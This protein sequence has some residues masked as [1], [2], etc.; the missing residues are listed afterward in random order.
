MS[1][2]WRQNRA[3]E[4]ANLTGPWRALKW[5]LRVFSSITLAVV[6]LLLVALYGVSA[7]VPIGLL[8]LAPTYLFYAAALALTVALLVAAPVW[9]GLRILARASRTVRFLASFALGLAALAVALW[10]WTGVFW[11]ALRFE[12]STGS[13]LRFFGEFVAAN[14]A[15]TLRRLP[16]ME[17]SELE[18]YSWWPLKLVLMLFVMNMV[19]AT[20]RRI[21]FNFRN[22]GVLTVHTGIITIAL[23]SVY[24]SGLKQE[25]DTLLL[26]GELGPSGRPGVGPPQDRFFDNTR[27]AL[28][29]DQGR[30]VEQRV[31]SGVPRYNDYNLGAVAGESA[32]ET[33]GL[34][35]PWA[36]AQR[37]L[38]V[39]VPRSR[40]GLCDPDISL[41]IVGYASYAE[42]VEDYVKVEAG[43]SGAPLRVVYLHSAVPDA[44]TG[45][46]PQGPVFAFFLSPAAP[47]DRVSE[48]D[49]FGV[50]YTLGPS[51]GMSQARW[52]DLSEPLP[53]GAEHGLVVEIPASSFRGA[54][55]AKVGET[56]TI[57]D[58]GYRVEVRELRPT[59][60]FP[61]IT[62]GYRGATS[63]VA[64]VRVTAPDGAAFDRYVYHRFPEINQ[65]VLGATDEGRP[66][67]RDADPAIRVSLVE[68][69]RLQ[70]YI[71]E[72][73][74]GQTRAI[75]RGAQSV[76][77]FE[78]DQIGSEGWIRG[79]A[80]DLVS[81]RVGERWDRAIK[82]E[83]PA[84]VSEE[85]QDRRLAGTHDAAMLGVELR[86]PGAG[87]GFR[88][89][90][91]LPFNKY[92]GIMSGAERKIDLPDGR[93]IS[94]TFG[95]M[96][97][98]FPDF[99]IQLSDFQM[100]AYDHRGAPRDYQSVVRV[101]PMDAATFRQFEH[102]TKLNNPLRAPSHWDESR[103][104]IANAAGRLA[105]GLSPRQFKLS[106][107]GWDAAGWQRTQAQADAG[108]IP[109]PY[110]SFTILGV[111]N[112]PGIHIIAFGGILMA[113]GI[114]WA[115]YLKPYLVRRKKTRIQQQLAAGTYPVP[116]RAPA[117]SP[118]I[119]PVSQM[120]TPLTEVSD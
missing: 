72:P 107:A 55:E 95:R 39:P 60:P 78:T 50:E 97:H 120:T 61:I 109:G 29:V 93:A 82:I 45:Q 58:T 74:P 38:R 52:R 101:T 19:I 12:P 9:G 25:G 67:R 104:W 70:V 118:A 103:P 21:E 108:I 17:M 54:Y 114:P 115:F 62:E 79:V 99:A 10:M 32:W 42:P 36:G 1:A 65:D 22:I 47:A 6:L 26:A 57:G 105:G 73:Q 64:V 5:T 100:I 56:I 24:Y 44:N 48:N 16:G 119:Q 111:G 80:G 18:Y 98:R 28:F 69:D 35:R 46:V 110:A 84:P 8:A 66:I 89:V 81:L 113:I 43:T 102:V 15:V 20:V 76:R 7:S 37:D 13:G 4:D 63:S 75:V 31:L 51:G 106:Q 88:R 86:A 11:P 23:G 14:Q 94:L 117:A 40:Y 34:K 27:V 91:W 68:A 2:K 3:W 53:D 92:V 59:P 77:V 71:D 41:E 30:G 49:A 83:R 85:R 116:S 87:S 33:A 90:V 112:N 96:Q